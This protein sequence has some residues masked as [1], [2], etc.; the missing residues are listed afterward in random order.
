MGSRISKLIMLTVILLSMLFAGSI[1]AFADDGNPYWGAN[2]FPNVVLTDQNGK[3]VK[4]YDDL[5]KGKMVVINFIYTFCPDSCPLE[6]AKLAQ[7]QKLLG[8][9]VGKDIFFYSIS[10][11][12]KRDTPQE[13]KDYA[14]KFHVKPGWAFLTGDIKDVNLI[15]SKLGQTVRPFENQLTGHST[16][17]TIGNEKTGQWMQ[18]S[19]LDDPR[20]IAAMVGEWLDSWKGHVHQTTYAGAKQAEPADYDRGAYLF[21]TRCA[22]CHTV[23]EGEGV[24][25]DLMGVT[26]VR[27]QAW[28]KRFIS[29]P[30]KVLASDDV[31]AHVLFKKYKQIPMPNLRL[32]DTDITAVL[33]FIERQTAKNAAPSH[34]RASGGR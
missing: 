14:A 2:Y 24:G 23:G 32:G 22:A 11:D 3:K 29:E 5:L 20:Y 15:R 6:T 31:V 1:A 16:S 7:V 21:K 10:I 17:L 34:E 13:L 18:D 25:P 30:D 26:T 9:R 12:P 8:D 28:L 4:F 19:S 27:S 33:A